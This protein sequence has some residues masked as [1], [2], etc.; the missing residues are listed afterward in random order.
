MNKRLEASERF[1]SGD[2]EKLWQ[3][4]WAKGQKGRYKMK[5]SSD[6]RMRLMLASFIIAIVVGGIGPANGATITVGRAAGYDFS[7]IQAGIDAATDGDTILVAPGEYVITE[8]ITFRGKAITVRSEAGRDETTI[9][10][11]TPADPERGTVV[12]FENNETVESVLDGFTITG[13]RGSW[14]PSAGY[15]GG[16]GIAFNASSGAVRDCAVVENTAKGGGGVLAW[17]GAS[18]TLTN[19]TISV[20]SATGVTPNVDGY[21]GGLCCGVGSLLTLTNCAVAE[22]SAGMSGGGLFCVFNSSVTMT[23]CAIT[24]NSAG[25]SGA[26][27]ECS[28]NS[29]GTLTNCVITGNSAGNCSGGVN[30]YD[31][32]S[33]A[34][35]NCTIAANSAEN[36]GGAMTCWK[37]SS[38]TLTNCTI[39]QNS[40]ER[41]GG[42]LCGG[43]NSPTTVINCTIWG[44][45]AGIS[46]GGLGCWVSATVSNSILWGN[47]APEGPEM[48]AVSFEWWLYGAGSLAIMYSDVAGG[49]TSVSVESGST[50]H[51]GDGNIDADPLLVDPANGDYHLKSQAGRW[52]P[53]SQ[54]WVQD[55][56]TSPCIDAGDPMSPIGLEPFPNGGFVNM[57]VYGGTAEASKSYFGEPV[58]ETIVAGDINGDC[59]VDLADF[60]FMALHWLEDS[61]P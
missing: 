12:V 1:A 57:G 24:G 9:R 50:L 13:G 36:S 46:G 37:D 10:M 56:V 39:V 29:S 4:P 11:G 49:Q 3:G 55:D 54:A 2:D 16:G 35:T 42:G 20:N 52:D 7:A 53:N 51:W 22:N 14:W 61:R 18:P 6:Y 26:G 60:A 27:V 23:D 48:T 21:G 25:D 31:N 44:N 5:R 15:W 47:M 43:N 45:S 41:Y 58:C 59:K 38:M 32:S 8:P 28:V 34:M 40:A 17:S 19:C 30:C 33:L